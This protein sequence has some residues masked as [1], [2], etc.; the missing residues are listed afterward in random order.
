MKTLVLNASYEPVQMIDWQKA[1]YMVVTDKAEIVST[2]KKVV[3]SVSQT[4]ALPKV[5][6]LKRYIRMV[7][8][9]TTIRYS[10]RNILLRDRMEC[11]YCGKTCMASEATLDHVIPRSRGGKS[12]WEN[13]VTACSKCNNRKDDRTP[14]E[15]NMKLLSVPK[16]PKLS[17]M[18]RE[19]ILREFDLL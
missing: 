18:F 19:S 11:Q 5:I 17:K 4:M 15:A 2:Y 10:R 16:K 14:D 1:I 7:S 6:K 13:V 12:N 8:D 9:L 3:R